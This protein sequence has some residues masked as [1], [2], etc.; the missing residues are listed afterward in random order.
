MLSQLHFPD[1]TK[2]V[3]SADGLHVSATL[4]SVEGA[5]AMAATNELPARLLRDR[6]IIEHPIDALLSSSHSNAEEIRLAELVKANMF[7]EKLSFLLQVLDQWV[8]G[9]GLGCAQDTDD[10]LQWEGLWVKD[11]SKKVDWV[12]VGRHGGDEL[13]A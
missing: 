6:E 8:G 3:F 2:L 9:G 4:V 5:A 12:T 11:H 10:R 13:K 1:H 7:E